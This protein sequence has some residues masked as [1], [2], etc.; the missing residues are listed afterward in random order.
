M[1]DKDIHDELIILDQCYC[2]YCNKLLIEGDKSTDLCCNEQNIENLNGINTCKTCGIV[3]GCSFDKEYT[4]FHTNLF[5]IRKKSIYIRFY[6]LEN[7]LNK[8][9]L[10]YGINLI[11]EER[12][13]IYR[14][15]DVIDTIIH[16]VNKTGR[17]RLISINY[18]LKMLFKMMNVTCD[19]IPV[20]KS[21]K[22]LAFYSMYWDNV[23]T[24]IGDQI[25]TI[26]DHKTC[27]KTNLIYL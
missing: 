6:H 11:N 2:P 17:K 27:L 7:I 19:N 23:M 26:I 4:D 21:K 13:K 24:L 9:C 8:M 18:I 5:K 16:K 1:C 20:S 3:H 14:I 10:D 12:S 25:R 22:T 15:F